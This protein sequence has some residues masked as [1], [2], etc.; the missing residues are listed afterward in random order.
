MNFSIGAI[1]YTAE[2]TAIFS[3]SFPYYHAS[4]VFAIPPAKSYT[5][6]EKIFFPFTYPVWSV[7]G[8]I[9]TFTLL[10]VGWLKI[11]A[12]KYRNFVIGFRNDTPFFNMVNICFGGTIVRLPRQ[13]FARTILLIWLMTS[14]I[15]KSAYQGK[16]YHFL[17]TEQQRQPIN[18]LKRMMESD[19]SFYLTS[20]F[21][22]IFYDIESWRSM[23]SR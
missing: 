3:M 5:S 7:I 14:M 6:L 18:T 15:L 1:I 2:R 22:Q 11:T 9:F 16:L 17:R 20:S 4:F 23:R 10:I 19:L 21:F 12:H 8:A 13:N